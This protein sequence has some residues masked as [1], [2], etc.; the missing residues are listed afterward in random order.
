MVLSARG[1]RTAY[2]VEGGQLSP[3]ALEPAHQADADD[4]LALLQVAEELLE[5]RQYSVPEAPAGA[6]QARD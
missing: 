3:S 6:R 1:G 2:R 4:A 5:R